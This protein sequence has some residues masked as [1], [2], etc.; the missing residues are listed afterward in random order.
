VSCYRLIDAEKAHH[1]VSR[2][3]RVLGVSR[4][5]DYAWSTRPP[6]ARMLADQALTEQIRQIHQRSRRTYGAPRITPSS[7]WT[8]AST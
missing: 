2:L 8:T 7:G 4:A 6:S 3:A 5:G 1:P